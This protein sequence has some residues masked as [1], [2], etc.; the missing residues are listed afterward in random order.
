MCY[1][2]TLRGTSHTRGPL[3]IAH[4]SHAF[5]SCSTSSA[6][7]WKMPKR[8]PIERPC[9]SIEARE[10][11]RALDGPYGRQTLCVFRR[12]GGIGLDIPFYR[13]GLSECGPVQIMAEATFLPRF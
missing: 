2:S 7:V 12:K 13:T 3:R 5:Q 6:I 1:L 9:G 4:R 8:T 10:A 11:P